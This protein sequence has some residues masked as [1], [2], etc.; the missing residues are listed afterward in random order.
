MNAAANVRRPG[1]RD[2]G[3]ERSAVLVALA[4][5]TAMLA[6]PAAR[7]LDIGHASDV[8][9][10]VIS[11]GASKTGALAKG[12]A[13]VQNETLTSDPAGDARLAFTDG[14]TLDIGHAASVTLDKFVFNP[15]GL[16]K[17]FILG[18]RRGGFAFAT[19]H[20][21][22]SAY[23]I[24]TPVATIGVRGTRFSFFVDPAGLRVDVF[25]GRVI[26][27]LKRLVQVKGKYA[28][29]CRF[30][31]AGQAIVA[32]ATTLVVTQAG[33]AGGP[34]PPPPPPPEILNNSHPGPSSTPP[35]APPRKG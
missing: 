30:A 33:G 9:P 12:D 26:V 19:G 25:E 10:L 3:H 21:P 23:L 34:P 16:A 2:M 8:G 35:A 29:L 24:D 15:N 22:H 32:T 18:A 6:A 11:A 7:A 28:K 17:T 31:N 4:A 20:S 5:V 14:T 27:C 13:V 1:G